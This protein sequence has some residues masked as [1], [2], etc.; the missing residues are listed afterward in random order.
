MPHASMSPSERELQ[1]LLMRKQDQ[2]LMLTARLRERE[3]LVRCC[4]A[5]RHELSE[6]EQRIQEWLAQAAGELRHR[7]DQQLQRDTLV[8]QI[9]LNE[10]HRRLEATE[11]RSAEA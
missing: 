1:Q 9:Q 8:L 7:L 5:L 10:F 4:E 3:E 2:V 11:A 6:Q